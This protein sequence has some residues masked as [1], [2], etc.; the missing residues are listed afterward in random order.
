MLRHWLTTINY[1]QLIKMQANQLCGHISKK[2]IRGKYKNP[3]VASQKSKIIK[4]GK[5]R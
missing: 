2:E 4:I 3:Q 5:R 1:E